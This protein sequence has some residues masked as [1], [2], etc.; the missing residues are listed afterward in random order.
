M[1][2]AVSFLKSKYEKEETIRKI[3]ETS[4]DYIHVDLMDGV[5][6]SNNNINM[7]Q[8]ISL[9]KDS[10]KP[11][12]VHLMTDQ[13]EPYLNDLNKLN[14][15]YITFHLESSVDILKTIQQ[16][17]EKNIKVGLTIKPSTD[18]HELLPY[19][20]E[21]DLVLIMSVEPGLGG[22]KFMTDSIKRLEIVKEYQKDNHFVISIDGGI[23]DETIKLVQDKVDMAVSGSFV[24]ESDDFEQKI[25]QLK[26][27][28]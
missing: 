24:C 22:Q 14:V 6:V 15:E 2:I 20:S 25:I 16:I 3:E 13:V 12:D 7:P 19:L 28:K 26:N 10:N 21:I 8:L 9:L 11:L 1:K 5:F 27:S 4:A 23:N 17:K 18:I